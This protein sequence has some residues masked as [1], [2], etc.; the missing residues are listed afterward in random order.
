VS[1]ISETNAH[2]ALS[3]TLKRRQTRCDAC[4]SDTVDRT[5]DVARSSTGV[6]RL[7]DW[8]PAAGYGVGVGVD[9]TQFTLN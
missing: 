6:Y 5:Y 1:T 3:S 4:T 9:L 8:S 2:D 7:V